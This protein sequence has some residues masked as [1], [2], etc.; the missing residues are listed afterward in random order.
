MGIPYLHANAYL[1][2]LL[3]DHSEAELGEALRPKP[4]L[5]PAPRIPRDHRISQDMVEKRWALFP[6]QSGA[7]EQLLD[8]FSNP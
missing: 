1:E 4:E 3:K 6:D 2:Q 5:E 8:R 7:R